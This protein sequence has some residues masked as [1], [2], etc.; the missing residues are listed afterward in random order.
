MCY[1]VR[2]VSEVCNWIHST[3]YVLDCWP[4]MVCNRSNMVLIVFPFFL[5]YGCS[6]RSAMYWEGV[7]GMFAVETDKTYG[8]I[9]NDSKCPESGISWCEEERW[10]CVM[11]CSPFVYLRVGTESYRP[12]NVSAWTWPGRMLV[13]H[14]LEILPRGF[15]LS[16]V[17][18]RYLQRYLG[19]SLFQLGT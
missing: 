5:W 1:V 9:C 2:N 4:I 3:G 17:S 12:F 13:L 19:F 7:A 6:Y 14:F 8:R 10:R 15:P 16:C 11:P 18:S